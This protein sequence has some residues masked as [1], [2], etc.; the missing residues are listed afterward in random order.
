MGKMNDKLMFNG[1]FK[2]CEYIEYDNQL[3]EF[4]DPIIIRFKQNDAGVQGVSGGGKITTMVQESQGREV[5]K[6]SANIRVY[7]D[8]NYKPYDQIKIIGEDTTYIIKSVV[9]EYDS[10]NSIANLAFPN[11]KGNK[12]YVL[13]IGER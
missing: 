8:L 10:V 3:E 7:S 5:Y 12:T 9:E 13:V 6:K 11:R 4:K 1:Y 2:K